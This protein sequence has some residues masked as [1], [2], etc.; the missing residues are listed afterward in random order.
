METKSDRENVD[1]N[2]KCSLG[3]SIINPGSPM[4]LTSP[5]FHLVNTF[6]LPESGGQRRAEGHRTI[7]KRVAEAMAP[8]RVPVSGLALTGKTMH[9]EEWVLFVLCIITLWSS[10]HET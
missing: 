6:T 5:S 8:Q 10:G 4:L 9:R 3:E 2:K 1:T 7:S